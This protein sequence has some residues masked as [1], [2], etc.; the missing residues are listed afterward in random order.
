MT[1]YAV[2]PEGTDMSQVV[3]LTIGKKY[4]II[5]C[6]SKTTKSLGLA[7]T[8]IDDTDFKTDCLQRFCGSLN[9]QN[10]EIQE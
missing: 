4:E 9:N 10:W 3:D 2:I 8:I 1:K 7:F 6:W 5:G